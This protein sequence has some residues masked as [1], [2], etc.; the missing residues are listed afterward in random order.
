[1]IAFDRTRL[2]RVCRRH[3]VAVLR[4]FGSAARGELRPDSDVDLLVE[5]SSPKGFFELI[6]LE[7]DLA[8]LLGRP[9]DLVTGP[10]LA[11]RIRHQILSGASVIFDAAA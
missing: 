9:V 1:M 4:L 10:G 5:F 2:A 8:A 3:D 11:P 7:D 6:R